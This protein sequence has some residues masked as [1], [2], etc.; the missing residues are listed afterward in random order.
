LGPPRLKLHIAFVP[1]LLGECF[2]S[3]TQAFPLA[4]AHL[5]EIGYRTSYITVDGLSSSAKNAREIRDAVAALDLAA[6]ERLVLIG[7]SKG[8]PDILEGLVAY[9][10]LRQT[11]SAVVSISGAVRGSPL[12]DDAPAWLLTLVDSMPGSDCDEEDDLAIESLK[13][14]VRRRFLADH[15][16]PADIRYYS[17]GSFTDRANISS[18][19]R[20]DYDALAAFDPRND[21]QVLFYDQIIPGGRLLGFVNADHWAVALPLSRTHPDLARAFV[22][23]NAFPREILLEAV[24]RQVEEDLLATPMPTGH[25]AARRAVATSMTRQE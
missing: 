21:S 23:R 19:L 9:P 1:G 7:Y 14:S 15:V 16:L 3:L 4:R 11:A 5:E 22:D 8:V 10:A 2:P 13:P 18:L 17:L 25:A 24:V 12:S 6:D 20:G